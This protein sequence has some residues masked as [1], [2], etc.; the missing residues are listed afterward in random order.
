MELL[1]LKKALTAPFLMH[2][3]YWM[4]ARRRAPL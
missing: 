3:F 2:V 4:L 1:A